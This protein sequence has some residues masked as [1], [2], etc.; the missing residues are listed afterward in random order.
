[1]QP[2]RLERKRGKSEGR[3]VGGFMVTMEN[4]EKRRK[5]VTKSV[6]IVIDDSGME[7]TSEGSPDSP[8]LFNLR[9]RSRKSRSDRL[10]KSLAQI[11][12]RLVFS[13]SVFFS[14]Y[15]VLSIV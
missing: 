3:K 15:H 9:E 14:V 11:P 8:S 5:D 12:G 1:M 6:E 7:M 4:G 13:K 10:L 2:R